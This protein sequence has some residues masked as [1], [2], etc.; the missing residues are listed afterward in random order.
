VLEALAEAARTAATRAPDA[1][2]V[3]LITAALV[4]TDHL[5]EAL[6]AQLSRAFVVAAAREWARPAAR[7]SAAATAAMA[8]GALAKGGPPSRELVA[9]VADLLRAL[10][11]PMPDAPPAPA[12]RPW[13]GG[14]EAATMLHALARGGGSGRA[15]LYGSSCGEVEGSGARA[16]AGA[17]GA[18]ADAERDE[19]VRAL[20]GW[21]RAAVGRDG[22]RGG[23]VPR[24][25]SM[26]VAALA[27]LNVPPRP[28]RARPA[29]RARGTR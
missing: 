6:R 13:C 23:M 2:S 21:T 25:L 20:A 27:R 17:G 18:A 14:A 4:R 7:R 29:P 1:L 28:A 22:Q 24:E 9:C 26:A 11:P 15:G 19:L 12:G 16:P 10:P 8:L 5:N 3:A